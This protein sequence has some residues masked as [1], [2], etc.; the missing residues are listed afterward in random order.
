MNLVENARVVTLYHG[1]SAE[2]AAA[3]CQNGWQPNSGQQS[4]NMGQARYLYLT[5]GIEDAAWFAN[6][7]GCDSIVAVTVP[8]DYLIVD[9]EDGV[10][11][12]VD[13]ELNSP[14]GLPGKVALTR[15]VGAN[16]F[17]AIR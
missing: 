4:G 3:L 6:E 9:P 10:G 15:A 13:E 11:D 1:T 16:A 2:S 5:T 14:H 12:T 17:K 8:M 7:R